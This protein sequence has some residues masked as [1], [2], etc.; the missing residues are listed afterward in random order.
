MCPWTILKSICPC[1]VEA[2]I[3]GSSSVSCTGPGGRHAS[4]IVGRL[5]LAIA[6]PAMQGTT[7][8]MEPRCQCVQQALPVACTKSSPGMCSRWN[9]WFAL[10]R[11]WP[12][13]A[14]WVTAVGLA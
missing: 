1:R 12:P 7:Q 6:A 13:G 5:H 3:T 11:T 4:C 9:E 14:V 10:H 2:L 8:Q